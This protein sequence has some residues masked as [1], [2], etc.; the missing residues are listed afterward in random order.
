MI[1]NYQLN[2]DYIDKLKSFDNLRL[3][4]NDLCLFLNDNSV[5]HQTLN[6]L[7]NFNVIIII[8]F[9]L[10]FFK[11]LKEIIFKGFPYTGLMQGRKI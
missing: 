11:V 5:K 6:N 2:L 7:I 4:T 10:D 3:N 9:N 8:F 1:K